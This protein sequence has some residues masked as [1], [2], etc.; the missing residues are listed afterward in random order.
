MV[1]FRRMAPIKVC[2]KCG[3][4]ILSFQD[5]TFCDS[6][7]SAQLTEPSM[8]ADKFLTELKNLVQEEKRCDIEDKLKGRIRI[9][10]VS[11]TNN[12]L[13]TLEC[14]QNKFKEGEYDCPA[15]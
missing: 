11:V 3:R 12:G 15:L 7:V 4:L 8:D 1:R 6:C 2:R 5:I 14:E 13:A 10:V 9:E